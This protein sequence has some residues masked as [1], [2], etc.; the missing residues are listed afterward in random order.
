MAPTKKIRLLIVDDSPLVREMIRALVEDDDEIVVVGEAENGLE[1][2]AAVRRLAPDIVTMD[3]EM[4]VMGGLEAIEEIMATCAVPIL[5]VTTLSDAQTAFDAIARGALDVVRKPELSA[6]GCRAFDSRL[7]LLASIKV[8]THIR[9]RRPGGSQSIAESLPAWRPPTLFAI[10]ASTGGPAALAHILARLPADLP[11]PVLIAQHI[12]AGFTAGMVS[13]L[14][15]LSPLSV[16]LGVSGE[17]VL[18]GR[19][20]VAPAER[21]MGVGAD[22]RILLAEPAPTDIYH[23]SCDRLLASA[24]EVYGAEAAGI[25]LT[26]MGRDGAAGMQR[27]YA[28]GGYTIAEAESSS[29]VFGMNQVAIAAGSIRRVL[30]LA[31][32]APAMLRL[33][34]VA[35]P[36]CRRAS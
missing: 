24:A 35:E 20:Y 26:G 25:I 3:I 4:P 16:R 30:P 18:P 17:P 11:V 32:I 2:I 28:A 13:W 14:D 5:V 36:E 27:I 1:A 21:H 7:K 33:L 15:A 12:S 10:A 34:R 9:S 6:A 19:V 31:E 8:I 29:V 22:R 23:P